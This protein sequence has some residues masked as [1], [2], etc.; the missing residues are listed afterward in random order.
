MNGMR[1]MDGILR[2]H[3]KGQ[4]LFIMLWI[5]HWLQGLSFTYLGNTDVHTT[6]SL[7]SMTLFWIH[8]LASL[9]LN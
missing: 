3:R 4:S 8:L 2:P 1:E 9:Y 5:V 6:A 7:L